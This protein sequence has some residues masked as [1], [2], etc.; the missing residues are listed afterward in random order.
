M[1]PGA[2]S[3]YHEWKT[4]RKI[5]PQSRNTPYITFVRLNI[6]TNKNSSLKE[7]SGQ[8]NSLLAK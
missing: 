3:L 8:K 6:L 4:Q 1:E 7:V 2:E 5:Y